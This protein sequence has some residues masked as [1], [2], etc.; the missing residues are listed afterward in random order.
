VVQ[1]RPPLPSLFGDAGKVAIVCDDLDVASTD[2][3]SLASCPLT[4]DLL[5]VAE[6]L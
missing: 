4:D 3:I 1:I 6:D 5:R 2:N